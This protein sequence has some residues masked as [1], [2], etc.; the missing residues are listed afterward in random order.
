VRV[1]IV[2]LGWAARAFH[3]PAMKQLPS[4]QLVGGADSDPKQRA[5]W[6]R[7]TGLDAFASFEELV[8]EGRPEAIV[9]AT[10]PHSHADLCVAALEA[11][12]HVLCEKPFVADVMQANR[13]LASAAAAGKQ[14]AVNHEFREMPIYRALREQIGAAD[15]GRLVFCQIW[16]LMDLA[17]WD[18]P[19][20]WRAAMPNRTLFEG[21][22]HLVDL[23]MLLFGEKPVAVYA[24]HSSGFERERRSDAIH[25]VTFEFSDGRLAQLTIDRLCKA[26]TRYVEVRA[27]CENASLRASHG[28]RALVQVGKKRAEKTG[29]RIDFGQGGLAWLERGLTRK[30]LARSRRD[31]AMHATG[32]LARQVS[33]AFEAGR[34]PP[35]SGREARDVLEVIE[36]AYRSA[37]T[38]QRIELA[39]L[40]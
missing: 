16:Q 8:E 30:S 22:V 1:G 36:A 3:V 11:G 12:L 2:G 9:V 4:V 17:P 27:D 39:P 38:G 34:E 29:L 15:I 35:S 13:V 33:A 31:S 20:A 7:Q 18:E 5:S 28:G 24:R 6:G 19:V 37:E 25:L 10:P 40:S 32:E 14:V 23:L 26:G 21:G